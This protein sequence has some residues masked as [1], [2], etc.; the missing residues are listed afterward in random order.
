MKICLKTE[1]TADANG[2]FHITFVSK[3]PALFSESNGNKQNIFCIL[4]SYAPLLL[5]Y[6]FCFRIISDCVHTKSNFLGV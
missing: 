5:A 4:W 6:Y 3:H 1:F 2:R